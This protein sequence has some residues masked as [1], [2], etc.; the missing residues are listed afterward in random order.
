MIRDGAYTEL[1]PFTVHSSV[2]IGY[3]LEHKRYTLYNCYALP[4]QYC[5]LAEGYS[6]GRVK[7]M[8]NA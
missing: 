5:A 1:I 3:Q 7:T 4:L 8:Q 2:W 6:V